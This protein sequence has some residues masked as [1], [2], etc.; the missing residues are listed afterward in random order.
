MPHESNHGLVKRAA[1]AM[2]AA[3]AGL[4][5]A[6]STLGATGDEPQVGRPAPSFNATDSQ[7]KSRRL[8]DFRGKTVVLEWTNADCPYTR[9]HYTSG[10]MQG[11]QS[12]AREHGIVWLS[13]ISSAPG[14]QGYVDGA[15]ADAL[16]RSRHAS[17]AAVLLDPSGDMGRL[18]HA[19]TTPHMFVIG[20][21]GDLKYMGGIDSIATADIDDIKNAEPYL[22]EAMLAVVDGKPVAHPVTR[23]YGCS[24][25]Y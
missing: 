20:P 25:K 18:Y 11:L 1:A 22:K 10:N 2:L 17:P 5:G 24:V 3:V 23:P 21:D 8:E 7:G 12:L 4:A 16:T 19:K 6:S 14:K 13:V 9:K 15:G